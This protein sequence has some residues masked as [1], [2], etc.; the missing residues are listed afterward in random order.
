MTDIASR[1]DRY[2]GGNAVRSACARKSVSPRRITETL[3]TVARIA[4]I[5]RRSLVRFGLDDLLAAVITARTD[6]MTQMHFTADWLDRK[7]RLLHEIVRA[8]HASFRRRF[9]VLLDCHL[10]LS[11]L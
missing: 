7:R 6:V 2:C 3:A 1:A 8:V 5:P 11:W 10:M 4:R 9:L